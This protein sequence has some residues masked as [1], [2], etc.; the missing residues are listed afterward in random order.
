MSL[1]GLK[2]QFNKANQYM[3]EKI[4]G[5]KGT[6]LDDDFIEMEKKIDVMGKLVEDVITKTH[7]Y[8]QPN[9]ASRAKM[10]AVN[11]VSKMRGQSKV[12]M[13]Q[14]PEGTL[15]EYMIK[16][17]RDL[18]DDSTFGQSLMETGET[19]K[20]LA[21]I[22]YNLEDNVKQNFIDPL[23][24]MQQKDLRE[25]NHYRKKV[26]GRRLDYDCKRRKK[27]KDDPLKLK[28]PKTRLLAVLWS[29]ARGQKRTSGTCEQCEGRPEACRRL[30]GLYTVTVLKQGTYN[31][32]VEIP[33]Q[34]CSINVTELAPSKNYLAV[35]SKEGDNIVNSLWLLSQAGTYRGAGTVFELS[36]GGSGCPG[37]CITAP[38]PTNR[39]VIVQVFPKSKNPGIAYSFVLP[40]DVPFQPFDRAA[41]P[42]SSS[43][44][45][46]SSS[47]PSGPSQ[48]GREAGGSKSRDLKESE[49]YISEGRGRQNRVTSHLEEPR[50][51]QPT[52][53]ER[54]SRVD[55]LDSSE[56]EEAGRGPERSNSYYGSSYGYHTLGGRGQ[57]YAYRYGNDEDDN[58]NVDKDPR[59]R[60]SVDAERGNPG[61][62][63][64]YVPSASSRSNSRASSSRTSNS[65]NYQRPPLTFP[66]RRPPSSSSSPS[67][68][69]PRPS[70][71]RR[72]RP[73]FPRRT[74]PT[75]SQQQQGRFI[76]AYDNDLARGFR[77]SASNSAVSRGGLVDR[78]YAR[79][80]EPDNRL[81]VF[82]RPLE[83]RPA[84]SIGVGAGGREFEWTISGLSECSRTC[85]GGT[86]ETQVVCVLTNS[87]T[88]V[89]V[90]PDNC[91]NSLKP[92]VQTVACSNMPCAPGWV[93]GKWSECS[94]TCGGGTQSR[95]I[96]CRQR[97]SASL[98]LSVS[99]SQCLLADKPAVSQQC[100]NDPCSRW[101]AGDWGECSAP[102]GEAERRRT[103]QCVDEQGVQIPAA[104]CPSQDQPADRERCNT[105]PCQSQWWY[106]H[107]SDECSVDCGAG[108]TSR[109]VLCG[110]GSGREVS[111][112][113]CRSDQRPY[114]TQRCQSSAGCG[115][116]W[117]TAP[118]SKCS[119]NCGA[120]FRSRQV[121]CVRREGEGGRTVKVVGEDLCPPDSKPPSREECVNSAC[122]SQYYMTQWSQCSVTCGRGVR[123]REVRCLNVKSQQPSSS[124][125]L[126][127]VP[128][129]EENCQ[130]SPCP[131][132]RPKKKRL[133]QGGRQSP[134]APVPARS[135]EERGVENHIQHKDD[136]IP[137]AQRGEG[138]EEEEEVEEDGSEQLSPLESNIIDE[139]C[140]DSFWN[141]RIVVQ[142]RLCYYDY[143][144]E[145]CCASCRKL[146]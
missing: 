90:T 48:L 106:T 64:S 121:I 53:G 111:E 61:L 42:H 83:Q 73:S 140:K 82:E 10:L 97:F 113:G 2:K 39:R 33:A 38:G 109:H 36:R 85:G 43:S 117:F 57:S 142:A 145:V 79:G 77:T 99:A 28:T 8:L 32:V 74:R 112:G 134:D 116:V 3:S 62:S 93:S 105:H 133:A 46:S 120:G 40:N 76:S 56:R 89:V 139:K 1:A 95:R 110:D 138:V 6:E 55:A 65:S 143:Y 14:Q 21:D 129:A 51:R 12:G 50:R 44:S 68:R 26:S 4:G 60:P 18:G 119:G 144:R 98:D 88:Q 114:E 118:W 29:P 72:T 19:F 80:V 75:S 20:Q 107:W 122:D 49:P 100:N 11:T 136:G 92:R 35:R 15:G 25:V 87:A 101:T 141:C 24:Q 132:S 125:D 45:S 108:V 81:Q 59:G 86:Q 5:A 84:L 58:D 123:T 94:V 126:A 91:H 128:Q 7:E 102:C 54:A 66:R 52:Q 67:S 70:F 16:H 41:P 78:T 63:S 9:P 130:L 30:A 146:P 115:T 47:S 13:Y 96:E 23:T 124:C 17:G 22:K 135:G 104:Y 31:P 103:V 27:E 69:L 137:S 127:H 131:V 34:A 37:K 71:P